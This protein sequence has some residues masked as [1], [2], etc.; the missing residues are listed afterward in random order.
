VPRSFPRSRSDLTV[1]HL[2]DES[3]VYDDESGDL[4]HLNPTAT[5]VLDLCDG[6]STIG[7][8]SRTIADVFGMHADQVEP[9]IRT[10][11]RLFRRGKLLEPADRSRRRLPLAAS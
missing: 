7:E 8:L 11:I 6:S 3:V 5:I 10:L 1:V 4:H 9:E 2:D